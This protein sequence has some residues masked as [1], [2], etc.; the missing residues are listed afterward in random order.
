MCIADLKGNIPYGT[1]CKTVSCRV[2]Q[3]SGV[4]VVLQGVVSMTPPAE[5]TT[6]PP[7]RTPHPLTYVL[8]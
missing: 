4:R 2:L 1:V 8:P 3:R 6:T 5:L 7:P